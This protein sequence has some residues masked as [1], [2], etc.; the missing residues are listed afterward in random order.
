ML[1]VSFFCF[2][3]PYVGTLLGVKGPGR[4]A[5]PASKT[6]WEN[7]SWQDTIAYAH[8]KALKEEGAWGTG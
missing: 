2:M 6:S 5:W 7:T 4:D 8:S 1:E 3:Q